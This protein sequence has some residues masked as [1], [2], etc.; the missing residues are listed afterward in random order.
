MLTTILSA[1]II[2]V[3]FFAESVFGF[4]GG[5]I[6]VPLLSLVLGVKKAVM[7][8]SA[9]QALIGFIIIKTWRETLWRVMTP[10][11]FGVF[12]GVGLGTYTF[13]AVSEVFLK[14]FLAG[15]IFL[16]LVKMIFFEGFKLGER[17]NWLFGFLSGL[18]GGWV[19]AIIGTGGPV[20]TMYLLAAIHKKISFRATII[21]TLLITNVLRIFVLSAG[22]FFTEEIIKMAL[23]IVPFFIVAIFLGNK[24][25]HKMDERFYRLVVYG[26]LFSS[27][28]VMLF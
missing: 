22:G 24:I 14:R 4:G 23:A 11:V 16:F 19:Q 15:M 3:A 27:A 10:V 13:V 21:M 12:W 1:V 17:R 28:I 6:S 5:L 7:L 8:I 18:G 9:F 2:C 20:F 25:H 26:I